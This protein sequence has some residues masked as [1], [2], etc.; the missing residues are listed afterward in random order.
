ML[1][2]KSNY[3][4]KSRSLTVGAQGFVWKMCYEH[5][6]FAEAK[7]N[8]LSAKHTTRHAAPKEKKEGELYLGFLG[9]F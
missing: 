5:R 6:V 1:S 4:T 3:V 8:E 2:M 9:F 7:F